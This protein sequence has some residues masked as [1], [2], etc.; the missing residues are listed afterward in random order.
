MHASEPVEDTDD[1]SDEEVEEYELDH[2]HRNGHG[3]VV[4]APGLTADELIAKVDLPSFMQDLRVAQIDDEAVEQW[5]VRKPP[6][7]FLYAERPIEIAEPDETVRMQCERVRQF[8][9]VVVNEV[10]LMLWRRGEYRTLLSLGQER[11]EVRHEQLERGEWE[12]L[13]GPRMPMLVTTWDRQHV[14]YSEGAD[15]YTLACVPT[16]RSVS[17]GGRA[18]GYCIDRE[19]VVRPYRP[20]TVLHVGGSIPAYHDPVP[21]LPVG[22]CD[23]ECER[24]ACDEALRRNLV[25]REPLYEERAPVLAAFRSR[26]ACRTFAAAREREDNEV[27]GSGTW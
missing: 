16:A 6:A 10:T 15:R 17:C 26:S 5:F 4:H 2:G 27:E 7:V 8:D 18:R 22:F 12:P 11:V 20:P 3:R 24:S 19:L 23:V 13:G 9:D 14:R 1:D 21:D 25:P